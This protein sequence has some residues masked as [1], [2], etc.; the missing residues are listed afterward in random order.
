M[1]RKKCEMCVSPPP[2]STATGFAQCIVLRCTVSSGCSLG[3]PCGCCCR[4]C[5]CCCCCNC[6][7]KWRPNGNYAPLPAASMRAKHTTSAQVIAVV[8]E[9][10]GNNRGRGARRQGR[11]RGRAQRVLCPAVEVLPTC[12]AHH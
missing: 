4:C 3:L 10:K 9:E 5:C 2:P 1:F 7:S 12:L 8:K 6:F 11:G